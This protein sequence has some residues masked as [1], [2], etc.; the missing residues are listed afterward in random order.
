MLI[1]R[2][3]PDAAE[4]AQLV[5]ARGFDPVVAPVLEIRTGT[6]APVP[7]VDA[8]LVTSRNA[9]PALDESYRPVRLLAV[10]RATAARATACGFTDVL[11]ADGDAADLILLAQRVL[12]GRHGCSWRT[13]SDKASR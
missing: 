2:P 5:A 11:H 13:G 6:L 7:P 3:E 8:V 4:T 12:R 10:G 9:L 1:T